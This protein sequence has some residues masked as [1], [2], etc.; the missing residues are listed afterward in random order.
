MRELKLPT[1]TPSRI[2]RHIM[3]DWFDDAKEY[4]YI[5]LG[6]GGPTGKT[7][8]CN[9][10]KL[11]GFK[12]F[13]ITEVIS[14]FMLCLDNDNHLMIDDTNKLAVIVLNERFH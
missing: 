12:A 5:I 6:S 10:L 7:W 8:I 1:M 14:E 3:S 13:E 2:L 11:H 9:G 4:T